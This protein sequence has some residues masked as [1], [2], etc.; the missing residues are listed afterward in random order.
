MASTTSLFT[1]LSGL[2]ANSRRLEVIG[3]NISNV[4]TTAFK[5]SRM[6]FAPMFSK[7][8][9]LGT[10]PGAS[11]GG[12]NPA[13]VGTGALMSSIQRSFQNGAVAATGIQT[14]VAIEGGGFFIVNQGDQQF[15]TR[16]GQFQFNA[17]NDLVT[18]T[19]DYV[20]GY[21][22][23]DNFE[24]VEG[25]LSNINI[26][27]GSLTI[28]EQTESVTLAGNMNADGDVAMNG[29]VFDFAAL[30][31]GGGTPIDG[32]ELLTNYDPPGAFAVGDE[33]TISGAE[34]GGKVLPDATFTVTAASTTNDFMDFMMEA[35]G[36]VP[37]G[38][39][40]AGQPTGGADPGG[41]TI[42]PATGVITL[43]GNW[44]ELNDLD[45]DATHFSVVDGTGA[46]KGN[47][48]DPA[49]TQSA[50]GESVRHTFVVYDSLG[51]PRNIDITMVY[52]HA[53]DTG[54]YWRPFV[55]SADDTD[56][57]LHLE[58]GD[59]STGGHSDTIPLLHFDNSGKLDPA[60][61]TLNVELDLD[62]TG[63]G[64]PM[65][66]QLDFAADGNEV[67]ALTDQ[68]GS[69]NIIATFQDGSPMGVLSDFSVGEDGLITGRFD[70]GLTRTVGQVVLANFRNPGG[71]IDEGGGRFSVGPNSGAAV[72]AEP[73]T[74]GT[75]RLIGGA[76]EQSNTELSE[77]FINMIMTSTG[78]SASS[79]VITTSDELL[80]QLLLIGR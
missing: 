10:V 7:N 73:Q 60:T 37:N 74:F 58:Q 68:A 41:Y 22:V 18:A 23:N 17:N 35:L 63:A 25:E 12:T 14:D 26:P 45:L 29:S 11:T 49:K 76:L 61:T 40:I 72:I 59:R 15:F 34:R 1:G 67:T 66:F 28:A 56:V 2:L 52:S 54:T 44:G 70:N 57:A 51:T 31:Q 78:Y 36:V 46:P 13:Q 53:D 6:L 8:F 4:N 5:S 47:P 21:L 20:Q 42:D 39:F 71:L 19:G 30:T 65:N 38:G 80:Q 24:L 79:R 16:N 75:G 69:S 62:M 9:G 64:D 48:F 55:H 33:I 3:N 77:E 43:N 50:D 27:L 32:T